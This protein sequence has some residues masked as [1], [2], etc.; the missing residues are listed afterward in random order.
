MRM[1]KSVQGERQAD[2]EIEGD[3]MC[4]YERGNKW[5]RM[6]VSVCVREKEREFE[7]DWQRER[8]N[9]CV[10]GREREKER[11]KGRESEIG[12]ANKWITINE[13]VCVWESIRERERERD[14][15]KR[16]T[17]RERQRERMNVYAW[18]RE[19]MSENDCKC[20]CER[21]K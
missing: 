10:R 9:V 16:K 8:V 4:V 6:T 1:N 17:E 12:R 11:E 5:V 2:R 21:E 19:K 7:R 13:R 3:W 18:E 14:K 20:V 15:D